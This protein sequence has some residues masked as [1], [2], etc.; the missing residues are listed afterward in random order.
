VYKVPGFEVLKFKKA[1]FSDVPEE[2]LER[3]RA[4]R[5]KT[6]LRL[7]IIPTG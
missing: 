1:I 3:S 5:G 6:Q 2:R 7:V 4:L